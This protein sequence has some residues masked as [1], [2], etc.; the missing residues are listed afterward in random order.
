LEEKKREKVLECGGREE[1]RE[2]YK[3]KKE[4]RGFAVGREKGGAGGETNYA[5]ANS[6]N[7]IVAGEVYGRG[8][9]GKEASK[10]IVRRREDVFRRGVRA[11]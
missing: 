11:V 8:R 10:N 4:W 3:Y 9:W 6:S 5:H 2:H 7:E 1:G